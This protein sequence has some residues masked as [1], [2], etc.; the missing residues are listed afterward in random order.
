MVTPSERFEDALTKDNLW[1][2]ILTLLQKET[3]YPYEIRER[4]KKRFGFY[5]GNVTAYIVMKKLE[6]EG[7]IRF[8][9][10]LKESGPNRKYYK[11]TER[12][13]KELEKAKEIYKKM[14]SVFK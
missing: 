12:G 6:S 2:Y 1:I 11:I 13:K 3:L 14:E 4:V 10:V 8:V 7:Y 9:R 5:P